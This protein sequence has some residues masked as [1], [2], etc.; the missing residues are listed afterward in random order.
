M[1]PG[2]PPQFLLY[3]STFQLGTHTRSPGTGRRQWV[4]V[5]ISLVLNAL[6]LFS[7]SFEE[8]EYTVWKKKKNTYFLNPKHYFVC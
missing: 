8:K 7:Y 2:I 4:M 3:S 5:K 1:V 6:C